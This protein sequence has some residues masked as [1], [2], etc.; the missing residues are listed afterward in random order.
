MENL[1]LYKFSE[2]SKEAQ[3]KVKT[4]VILWDSNLVTDGQILESLQNLT[5]SLS[6]ST[7]KYHTS[8]KMDNFIKES[9][10]LKE[11]ILDNFHIEKTEGLEELLFLEDGTEAPEYIVEKLDKR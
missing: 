6:K 9:N 2:L 3:N 7:N 1:K 11:C 8:F 10:E 4:V 5:S